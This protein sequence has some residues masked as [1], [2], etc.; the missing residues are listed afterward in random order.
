MRFG[1]FQIEYKA[2]PKG[3]PGPFRL[4]TLNY[5]SKTVVIGPLS[6]MQWDLFVKGEAVTPRVSAEPK[7]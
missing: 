2:A 7:Q 5:D 1:T 4:V 6:P 3:E